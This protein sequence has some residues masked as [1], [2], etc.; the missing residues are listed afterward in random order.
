MGMPLHCQHC[1]PLART[2]PVQL[3]AVSSN[4][5][6]THM[7]SILS[8]YIPS[9]RL[10]IR[11]GRQ[12]LNAS[13]T[14]APMPI[15][16][17]QQAPPEPHVSGLCTELFV[18]LASEVNTC[19]H[20]HRMDV[21]DLIGGSAFKA[22]N[23]MRRATRSLASFMPR[24]APPLV[25]SFQFLRILSSSACHRFSLPPPIQDPLRVAL[26]LCALCTVLTPYN[27]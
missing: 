3:P 23:R 15:R 26:L 5:P 10:N 6:P 27:T 25:N 22:T 9:L 21:A 13:A 8:S 7:P 14:S 16:P 20:V 12:Y 17:A 4:S 19:T 2:S 18:G 24:P 1:G 11:A